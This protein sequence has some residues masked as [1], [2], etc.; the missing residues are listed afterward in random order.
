[1]IEDTKVAWLQSCLEDGCAVPLPEEE[2]PKTYSG[3]FMVRLSPKL[4]RELSTTAKKHGVSL[5]HLVTEILSQDNGII[6]NQQQM[7]DHLLNKTTFQNE[8]REGKVL[9]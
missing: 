1:M 5:N 9:I 6:R 4:H 7:I 8:S 2:T 3:K